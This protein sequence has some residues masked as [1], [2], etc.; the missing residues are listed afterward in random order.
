MDNVLRRA[1]EEIE[2]R[3]WLRRTLEGVNG[4]VCVLGAYSHAAGIHIANYPTAFSH[5]DQIE[6]RQPLGL[7]AEAIL[8]NYPDLVLTATATAALDGDLECIEHVAIK[9]NDSRDT[10][11]PVIRMLEKAAAK[12]DEQI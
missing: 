6:A 3:G 12:L 9:F 11:E 5:E 8:E 2:T 7:L 10:R 1:A 4:K